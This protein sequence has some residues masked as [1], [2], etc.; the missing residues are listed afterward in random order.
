MIFGCVNYLNMVGYPAVSVFGEWTNINPVIHTDGRRSWKMNMNRKKRLGGPLKMVHVS[1]SIHCLSFITFFAV[2]KVFFVNGTYLLTAQLQ[3]NCSLLVFPLVLNSIKAKMEASLV[4]LMMAGHCR[5]IVPI[6][7]WPM[8]EKVYVWWVDHAI[9]RLKI[10]H[11]GLFFMYFH[12]FKQTLQFLQQ[13][14]VKNVHPVSG[15]GIRTHNLLIASL[16][17][18]GHEVKLKYLTLCMQEP[19]SPKFF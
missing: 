5:F 15:T 1:P 2:I 6:S 18:Y 8:W 10:G 16:L 7:S 3:T 13:I 19:L 4:T 17:P 9:K 12:L 14:N 11:P